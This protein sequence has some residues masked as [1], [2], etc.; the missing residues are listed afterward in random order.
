MR[1]L[2]NKQ[3][4]IT[5][6]RTCGCGNKFRRYKYKRNGARCHSGIRPMNT[7]TCKRGC[8][9]IIKE[10]KIILMEGSKI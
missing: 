6:Q 3:L 9:G 2:T 7:L 5:E 4:R 1:T 8:R 10:E